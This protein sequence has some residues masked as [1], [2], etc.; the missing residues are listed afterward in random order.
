MT[1]HPVEAGFL[2]FYRYLDYAM[3]TEYA[4]VDVLQLCILDSLDH[5]R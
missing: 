3:I 4:C 1:L 2:W 5:V